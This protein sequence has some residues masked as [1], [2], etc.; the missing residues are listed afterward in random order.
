MATP[1]EMLKGFKAEME[2]SPSGEAIKELISKA[3]ATRN[4]LHFAHWNTK[5]FATHMAVGDL[6][7]Q[8]IDDIDDIV[9]TYQGKFGILKGLSTGAQSAPKDVCDHVRAEA[10]WVESNRS[11][12]SGNST[13]IENLVDNLIGDY[14]KTVYKLENLK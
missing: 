5:S 14:H 1:K 11:E 6:Y 9:E 3:F 10:A 7:D 13:A 2:A 4:L 8:I 12:I